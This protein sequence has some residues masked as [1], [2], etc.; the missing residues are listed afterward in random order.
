MN[1]HRELAAASGNRVL[2]EVIDSLLAARRDEQRAV[3]RLIDDRR[4]D[5]TEHVAIYAAVRDRDPDAAERLTREHLTHLRDAM[6]GPEPL[7]G[8]TT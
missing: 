4:R 3:R 6:T 8:R 7:E 2:F 5:H 1:F